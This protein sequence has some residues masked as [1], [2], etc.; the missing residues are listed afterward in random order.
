MLLLIEF[1]CPFD[2]PF[3]LLFDFHQR[4]LLDSIELLLQLFSFQR[5]S[6]L[7]ARTL[8]L[9]ALGFFVSQS[10][11]SLLVLELKVECRPKLVVFLY[12]Q[13]ALEVFHLLLF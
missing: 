4:A 7:F 1:F 12:V 11:E 2:L 13:G 9:L 10:F 6:G 8:F 5:L 3:D